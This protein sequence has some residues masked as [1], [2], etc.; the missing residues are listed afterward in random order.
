MTTTQFPVDV[1]VELENILPSY[2]LLVPSYVLEE[3]EN[4]KKR[5]RGKNRIAASVAVKIAQNPPFQVREM[6]R[7]RGERVDDAL[8][9][10]S[11][12][13]CTN[14][15][16]LRRKARKKG[17]PVVYLRQKRYLS[18]DGHLSPE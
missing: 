13:L 4:I 8:L 10:Q 7:G 17:I 1:V 9:R 11:Q 18:L 15:R 14:D 2:K 5:S 3:L 16:E 12:V 6:E